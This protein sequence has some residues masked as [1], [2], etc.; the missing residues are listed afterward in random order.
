MKPRLL[1][2][3]A[4]APVWRRDPKGHVRV[5]AGVAANAVDLVKIGVLLAQDGMWEGKRVLPEGWVAAA[6]G[7]P[8]T[9]ASPRTGLGW[10]VW[11]DGRGFEHTG[12]S[13]AF[14]VVMPAAGI[15]AAGVHDDP[16]SIATKQLVT[17][18]AWQ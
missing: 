5:H 8:A 11:P 3:L 2:P 1:D 15:V 6:T 9:M 17:A 4:I 18:L 7:Q 16:G 14:L 13:G 12:D 10:F